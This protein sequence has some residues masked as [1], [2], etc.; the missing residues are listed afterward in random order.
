MLKFYRFYIC[1][2]ITRVRETLFHLNDSSKNN[3]NELPEPTGNV[4]SL[5]EKVYVPVSE[6]PNV[7]YYILL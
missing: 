5:Q 3:E 4:V 6:N 7:C 2:E 1:L